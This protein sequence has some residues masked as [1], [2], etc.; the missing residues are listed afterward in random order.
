MDIA[1]TLNKDTNGGF[2]K[3]H[4]GRPLGSKPI[5]IMFLA[6]LLNIIFYVNISIVELRRLYSGPKDAII[7]K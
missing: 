3:V 6:S 1:Q 2:Q 5:Y 4:V 7:G